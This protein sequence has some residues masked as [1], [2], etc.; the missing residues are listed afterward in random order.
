[1]HSITENPSL[2]Q[3]P[4]TKSDAIKR[5]RLARQTA[6]NLASS[7]DLHSPAFWQ[8]EAIVCALLAPL[9]PNAEEIPALHSDEGEIG[10]ES[11]AYE[12]ELCTELE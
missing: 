7:E 3:P 12:R 8:R 1:M 6:F 11:D 5:A 9:L 2:T 4:L 10:A